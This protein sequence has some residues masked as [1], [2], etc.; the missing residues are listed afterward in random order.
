M[1]YSDIKAIHNITRPGQPPTDGDVI[2]LERV[3]GFLMAVDPVTR[4]A[5]EQHAQFTY[6]GNGGLTPFRATVKV[7]LDSRRV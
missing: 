5:T 4:T 2:E 1:I 7:S 3:N 6:G